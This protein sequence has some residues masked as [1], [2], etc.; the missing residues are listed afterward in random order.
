M[1]G[2]SVL[3]SV[4]VQGRLAYATRRAAAAREGALGLQIMTP[5]L[6]AARLA[7]GLLRP[8]SRESIETGIRAALSQRDSLEDIAPISGYPEQPAPC[9]AP[10]EE[11]GVRGLTFAR[12]HTPCSRVSKIWH[13]SRTLCAF[14]FS[15][16]NAFSQTC[17]TSRR[18]P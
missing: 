5:S 6:L 9:F 11:F 17:A 18:P 4:L 3:H 10:Y 14:T 7:G 1:T 12:A 15:R 8:A 2:D 16:A 13:G